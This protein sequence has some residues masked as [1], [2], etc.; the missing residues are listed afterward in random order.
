MMQMLRAGGMEVLTDLEREADVDNPR[1]YFEWEPAKLLPKQP[2]LI[3]QA[4][5][6][7]VKVITQL[8]MAVPEGHQYKV[9]LMKRALPEVLASQDEMLRRRGN[10]DA[11]SHE[12]MS[13]A[14][15]DHLA[16]LDE[17]F[18]KRPDVAVRRQLYG[19]LID[20]PRAACEG[21]AKF[22][23]LELNLEAMAASVDPSL[24]RNRR[25]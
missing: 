3:A 21:I 8:L 5:G 14:F 20:A 15:R 17:W 9:I 4:E 10:S 24:Y 19:D 2:A 16:V 11:V 12:A 6:K 25:S 22:L 7:V 13:K 18:R 1:G 23:G